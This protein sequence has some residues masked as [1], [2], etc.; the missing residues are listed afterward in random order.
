M[1]TGTRYEISTLYWIIF[2]PLKLFDYMYRLHL[3]CYFSAV[4]FGCIVNLSTRVATSVSF[5]IRFGIIKIL[6][7]ITTGQANH[8]DTVTFLKFTYRKY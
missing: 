5:G 6:F 4:G 3:L 7:G 8:I 2:Y 1:C